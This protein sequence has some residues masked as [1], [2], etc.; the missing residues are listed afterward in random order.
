LGAHPYLQG[1]DDNGGADR[2]HGGRN[3]SAI[4]FA[5]CSLL[6][7]PGQN[8]AVRPTKEKENETD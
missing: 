6:K 8:R 7:K 3:R 1:R 2:L 4:Y 5:T